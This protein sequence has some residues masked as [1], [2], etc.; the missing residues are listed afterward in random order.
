VRIGEE[1]WDALRTAKRAAEP[2]AML[3]MSSKRIASHR[4]D[5]L[6]LK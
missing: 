2:T 4:F 5:A 1:D 6:L 3:P